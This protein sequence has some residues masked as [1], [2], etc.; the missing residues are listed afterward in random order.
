MNN[1]SH[2][3]PMH[4][5]KIIMYQVCIGIKFLHDIGLYHNDLKPENIMFVDAT[6]EN[7]FG[8]CENRENI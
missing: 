6:I 8:V 5:F 4:Y 1:Y 3:L 2:L 7:R